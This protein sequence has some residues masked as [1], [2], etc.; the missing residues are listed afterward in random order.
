MLGLL[1]KPNPEVKQNQFL[2]SFQV[3]CTCLISALDSE[4]ICYL[5]ERT[6]QK[7]EKV[8]LEKQEDT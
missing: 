8:F 3:T 1:A 4:K 6:K 5:K 2:P 7:K